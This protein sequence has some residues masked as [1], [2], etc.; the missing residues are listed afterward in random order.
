MLK[1]KLNIC[2]IKY[3]ESESESDTKQIVETNTNNTMIGTKS[4]HYRDGKNTE[5][6]ISPPTHL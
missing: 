2:L 1:C 4:V 6:C 5:I 3:V